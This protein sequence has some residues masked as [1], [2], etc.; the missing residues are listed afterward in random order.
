MGQA[1]PFRKAIV[2]VVEN[3]EEERFLVSMLFEESELD[4]IACDDGETAAAIMEQKP[5]E[6]AMVFA[7]MRLGGKMDGVDLAC[8]VSRKYPG[9][10]MIVTAKNH[11]A[12]LAQLPARAEFIAKPWLALD[13][14]RKAEKLRMAWNAS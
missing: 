1:R 12:R 14:L 13:L 3:D 4:V 8:T 5:G 2:L 9:V 7:D 6:I 11:S 10:A